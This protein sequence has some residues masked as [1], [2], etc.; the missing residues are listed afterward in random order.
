MYVNIWVPISGI[1]I[2]ERITPTF[3]LHE[4]V[5]NSSSCLNQLRTVTFYEITVLNQLRTVTCYEIPVLNQLRTVTLYEITVFQCDYNNTLVHDDKL[6]RGDILRINY[7][8]T[9][10][11]CL[12]ASST[13]NSELKW[14]VQF[15]YPCD[16]PVSGK[17]CIGKECNF[18]KQII[19][20]VQIYI[21]DILLYSCVKASIIVLFKK[22][23]AFYQQQYCPIHV[24]YQ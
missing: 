7:N 15:S 8:R 23:F 3:K 17:Q 12:I 5:Q 20:K 2:L 9:F 10:I 1:T 14:L 16:N 19:A 24:A 4:F 22:K 21:L 11:F 18:I 13:S 6:V